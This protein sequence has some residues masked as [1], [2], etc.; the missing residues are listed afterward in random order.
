MILSNWFAFHNHSNYVLSIL[1]VCKKKLKPKRAESADWCLLCHVI[2]CIWTL[3]FW[4][5]KLK[6]LLFNNTYMH[7]YDI[8]MLNACLSCAGYRSVTFHPATSC[9]LWAGPAALLWSRVLAR[10]LATDPH[11]SEILKFRGVPPYPHTHRHT[12]TQ[13]TNT[14]C[15]TLTNDTVSL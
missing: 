9:F 14:T 3:W 12:H 4:Q 2:G 6:D 11:R 10:Q 7:I 8:Y 15:H 13:S 5:V 1:Q